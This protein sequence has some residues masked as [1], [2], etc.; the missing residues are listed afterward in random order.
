MYWDTTSCS[1]EFNPSPIVVDVAGNGF[2]LTD[3]KR[4]VS[5][6]LNGNAIELRSRTAKEHNRGDGPGMC[7]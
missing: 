4:G 5:F 7:S 1:C 6:D 3:K 2:S